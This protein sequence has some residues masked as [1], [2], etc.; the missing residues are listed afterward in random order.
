M[1]QV[2]F[3]FLILVHSRKDEILKQNSGLGFLTF[4]EVVFALTN[5]E[6]RFL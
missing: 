3:K 6:S 4:R 2:D 1:W 5:D